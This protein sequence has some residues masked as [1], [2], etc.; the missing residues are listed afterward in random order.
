MMAR[1]LTAKDFHE[2]TVL[3]KLTKNY[4]RYIEIAKEL[5][6]KDFLLYEASRGYWKMNKE[7]AKRMKYAMPVHDD[8]ILTVYEIDDWYDAVS[9]PRRQEFVDDDSSEGD[10]EFVGWLA[11][12]EVLLKYVNQPVP[13][14]RNPVNYMENGVASDES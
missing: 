3:L 9:S 13:T 11:K 10:L 14:Y 1:E 4:D 12:E 8:K 5:N 2:N 7:K 6:P